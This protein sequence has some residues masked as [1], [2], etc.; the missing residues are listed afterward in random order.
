[1]AVKTL[2]EKIIKR[3]I[4]KQKKTPEEI[5]LPGFSILRRG[6]EIKRLS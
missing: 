5:I 3:V 6:G 2:E 1:M 4:N